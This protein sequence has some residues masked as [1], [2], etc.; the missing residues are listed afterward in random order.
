MNRRLA[1]RAVTTLSVLLVTASIA[2]PP[3]WGRRPLDLGVIETLS[4]AVPFMTVGAVVATRRPSHPIGWGFVGA[5]FWFSLQAATISYANAAL[6][7]GG[8]DLPGA[9]YAG[10][11]T[12]WVF[13]PAILLGYTLPLLWFPDGRTLSVRWRRIARGAAVATVLSCA[14]GMLAPGPLINYPR[15]DNP[16]GVDV[17][18]VSLVQVVGSAAY[19]A[20][21]LAAVTAV[22]VRYRRSR[23]LERLQMRWFVVGV[24]VTL[25]AVPLQIALLATTGDVGV[26][27]L[28]MFALPTCAGIAVL[29]YRLFDIDRVISR[30]LAYLL[31]S[32]LLV[33]VYLGCVAMAE[34][35][36]PVKSSAFG[37]A[38]S[39]LAVAALFHPVR[40]RVQAMVDHRYNRARYDAVR[41]VEA[42][43]VQLRDA[44]DPELVRS[45]LLTVAADAIQPST[46]SLWVAG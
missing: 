3:V 2:I 24:G 40:R 36:L 14:A 10:N 25:L 31:V 5:G 37:V 17:A 23:G 16:F 38:A 39:T 29:R 22:V 12:Q 19:A 21:M 34:L 26:G 33:G 30:A 4:F 9:V 46:I 20:A 18:S 7:P 8:P 45:D 28:P 43:A 32:G 11:V 6:R 35:T 1:N 44:V 41:T 15:A 27:V 13:I 42:F